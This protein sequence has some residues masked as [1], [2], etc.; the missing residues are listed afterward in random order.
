MRCEHS[1]LL[2]CHD[3]RSRVQEISECLLLF[4]R[5]LQPVYGTWEHPSISLIEARHVKPCMDFALARQLGSQS[6]GIG[7][8]KV[9]S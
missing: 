4:T 6:F 7:H 3:V 9:L 2:I 5:S 8:L 1:H